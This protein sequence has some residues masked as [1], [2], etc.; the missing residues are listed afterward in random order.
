MRPLSHL[1][2][3]PRDGAGASQCR[4]PT[5]RGQ[6]L[7]EYR[8]RRGLASSARRPLAL[9]ATELAPASKVRMTLAVPTSQKLN[10][11]VLIACERSRAVCADRDGRRFRISLYGSQVPTGNS[12]PHLDPCGGRQSDARIAAQ[13][14]RIHG[15]A[16]SSEGVQPFA[17]P[18]V[19]QVECFVAA[20]ER[21]LG[22]RAQCHRAN[23]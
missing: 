6:S 20:H 15:E 10:R 2:C 11:V 23:P 19:P 22:V 3:V 12:I 7:T 14:H 9:S 5:T 1:R 18:D 8:D 21:S 16:P 13:R 17:F 4:V